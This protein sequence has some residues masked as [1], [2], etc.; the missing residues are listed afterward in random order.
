MILNNLDSFV[1]QL[2]PGGVL[3]LSGPLKDDEKEILQSSRNYGLLLGEK[4]E[5]HNWICLQVNRNST[6][7]E[8]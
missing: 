3:V 1:K 5:E 7:P 2:L 4:I 8:C 6:L